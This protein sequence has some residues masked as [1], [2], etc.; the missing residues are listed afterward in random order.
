M[1]YFSTICSSVVINYKKKNTLGFTFKWV[2]TKD[3]PEIYT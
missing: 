2:H 3:L 1:K